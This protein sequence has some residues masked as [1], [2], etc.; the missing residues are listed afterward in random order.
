M[1][2]YLLLPFLLSAASI[3]HAKSLGVVGEV[4]PV[5]ETSLLTLIEEKLHNTTVST[6][7]RKDIEQSVDRPQALNLHRALKTQSHL[8]V[9]EVTLKT[10]IVD[11]EQKVLWKKGTTVNAL[12]ALP[13][14]QPHWIFFNSNDVAQLH[15]AQSQTKAK[16]ILTG[17]SVREASHLLHQEIFFDQGGRITRQLGISHVPASVTR[18]GNA[19][20]I[21]EVVIKEDGHE[22]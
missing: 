8:Y 5:A 18:E 11:G 16:V 10:D 22:A 1:S 4:F 3:T 9:P 6:V 14:Y 17:G 15:W 13:A 21:R 19:L 7:I 2:A 12:K 20:L